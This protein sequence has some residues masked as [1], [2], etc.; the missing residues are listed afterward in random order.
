MNHLT[1]FVASLC[2][3]ITFAAFRAVIVMLF[4]P[5]FKAVV[6]TTEVPDVRHR[7]VFFVAPL[8]DIP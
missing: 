6:Q 5:F 1:V 7:T 2:A 8:I 3:T 4:L